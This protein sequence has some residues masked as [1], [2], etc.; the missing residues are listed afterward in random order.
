[1]R[2]VVLADP[3]TVT[4]VSATKDYRATTKEVGSTFGEAIPEEDQLHFVDTS[5]A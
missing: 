4:K 1:M 5:E 2:S 3:T